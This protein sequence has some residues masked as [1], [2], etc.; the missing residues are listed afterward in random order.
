MKNLKEKFAVSSI[1]FGLGV[2]LATIV[3]GAFNGIYEEYKSDSRAMHNFV[4]ASAAE[5]LSVL[6]SGKIYLMCPHPVLQTMQPVRPR[7][8]AEIMELKQT[9]QC[10]TRF[11]LV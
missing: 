2:P 4:Q 6:N 8:E 10:R 1:I 5:Q 9:G 7:S 11:S 3:G